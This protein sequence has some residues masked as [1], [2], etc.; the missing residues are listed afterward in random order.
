MPNGAIFLEKDKITYNFYNEKDKTHSHA[1]HAEKKIIN[2]HIV[3][4]HAYSINFKNCSANSS[5]ST[6]KEGK[7]YSNY[8]IGKNPKNWASKVKNYQIVNYNNI[9]SAIDAKFK[10]NSSGLKYDFIVYPNGNH[11]DITLEFDGVNNLKIKNNNLIIKTSVNKIIELRPYA[12]QLI[13]GEKTEVKCEYVLLDN[14]VKFDLPN[15]Y[16][17][18]KILVIDPTLIFSTYSGST[19]D[20]WGMTATFDSNGN[21]FSGGI[22]F[23]VGFPVTTGA[24]QVNYAGGDSV[25]TSYPNGCDIGIIK[26]SPDGT[27]RLWA[28]YLGGTTSEELPHSIIV[29]EFDELLI[30]G[31]T[32]SSDFPVTPTAYDTSF[33][34]G[35]NVTY[36]NV[37]KFTNGTDIYISRLSLDGSQLISSTYIGGSANDGFNFRP[38]YQGASLMHGNDS[39]YYN[40]ADGARGE[41][42]ADSENNIYIGT[43]TFSTDFPTTSSAFQQTSGGLQDGVVCKFDASLSNLI[44]S[45]YIGGSLDDAIYSIDVNNS[46][47]VYVAGGTNSADFVTTPNAFKQNYQGGSADGFVAHISKYGNQIISSTFFGSPNYDQAYFVRLDKQDIVHI[48]GQTK[49]TDSTL[50]YNALYNTPNSG[51]FI[52]KFKNDLDTIEWSTVFGTGNGKPNISI[53]AFAVDICN[54][55]YLS[56]WGREWPYSPNNWTSIEGT[57][58]MDITPNA[59]QSTTDGQ[60]FYIMVMSNDASYLDYGSF[61]GEYQGTDHV[62][63]GTSRFDKRGNIYQS[64]CASC[65]GTQQF[66]TYPNPGVWSNSNNAAN[67]NNAVFRFSFADDFSLAEF[68]IPP[69]GCAPH[70][71]MFNNTSFGA[72][73]IWDFGDGSALSND[74][75]PTHTYTT[76]GIYQ[77]T[78]IANDSAT[79]N[80][81]DTIIK[82]IQIL[83][84]T[85]YSM[86]ELTVCVNQ[87]TQIGIP[88]NSN[89]N[90]TYQ[91][92]PS[93][94]LSDSTISNPFATPQN[95][96]TYILIVSNGTCTDTIVQII[97]VITN[98]LNVIAYSDTSVC[99]NQQINIYAQTNENSTYIWSSNNLFTDTLNTSIND[100]S[101]NIIPN[102]TG[103]YYVIAM[104]N[105]CGN[106]AKDSVLVN[107]YNI[108]ANVISD[109]IACLNDTIALYANNTVLGDTLTFD[110]TPITEIIS[111]ANTSTPNISPTNNTWYFVEYENQF[112]CAILDSILVSVDEIS[113][114]NS[115]VTDVLCHNECNGEISV[116]AS[117]LG[118]I[119][120]IWTGGHS[121]TYNFNLCSGNYT[122]VAIDSYGC[123]DS[124]ILTINNPQLLIANIT[125]TTNA[126]CN[127]LNSNSGTATVTAAGGTPNYTYLWSNGDN[128]IIADSL[129]VGNYTV[130]VTDANL[131]DT[132]ISINISDISNMEIEISV[133]DALCFNQ[134]DG[135]ASINIITAGTS[136]YNYYW[137]NNQNTQTVSNL[138][139]G[140]YFITVIDNDNCARLESVYVGQPTPLNTV[141][142]KEN[143]ICNGDSA[144]ISIN[145]TTGGTPNYS[146]LWNSV[147]SSNT[148]FMFAGDGNLI[149]IDS[150]NC[151][152]TLF[153]NLYQPEII[154]IDTGLI[155]SS[156]LE[157]CNGSI[158]I[159]MDGGVNPYHYIWSNSN[160]TTNHLLNL[161]SGEYSVTMSDALG[162]A[163]AYDFNIGVSNY[164]PRLT[165]SSDDIYIFSGE[166]TN[167][168][169]TQ[170]YS[171]Y[172][173][174]PIN[175]LAHETTSDVIATPTETTTYSLSIIDSFGCSTMDTIT[176]FVS[177]LVC[178]EPYIYV[179]N[180]FSPNDDGNN[181]I[182]Y[183]YGDIIDK[184]YF[185]VYDRWGEIV[186][187]TTDPK[188]GWDGI[189]KGK[190]AD[191]AVFVYYLEIICLNHKTFIK[192]GNVTL[193]R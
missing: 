103:Y 13:N 156:C 142:N 53:T 15:G 22:V 129:F 62:D 164:Y 178:G 190:K 37:I 55:M 21:V 67:C 57:K 64:I 166:S 85:T 87:P 96:I 24:Y 47:D 172:L 20:N 192:K 1:H 98:Q 81:A 10:I 134:C 114:A 111:G 39:L 59:F 167:I 68:D 189:Y 16:D 60:D 27:Q 72:Y 116:L 40:Y 84:D 183:V 88:P 44:F 140:N 82:T 135:S 91:W 56:G 42:I 151:R 121:G 54:R 76:S 146:Y 90:F 110:W 30:F 112:G 79:C 38:N 74:T 126:A 144:Q 141:I 132:I 170:N 77:I 130:T 70:T 50:V 46:D 71:V 165:L 92:I 61:F 163:K 66:P 97:N 19:A 127:G 75:N 137:S 109:T 157:S 174:R 78:L 49:A 191:P 28:S 177:D 150:H 83:S 187:A 184:L 193:I 107:I 161:C 133:T 45:S 154:T 14:I 69:T 58:N 12:Y 118:A 3:N 2:E 128:S 122:I 6:E 7:F 8:F 52:T 41:I 105:I 80:L 124:V 29:N 17:K 34:G 162:C 73:Y 149:T 11:N 120:Y 65:G 145:N 25:S 18:T 99:P 173:W 147:D 31:V 115:T 179:P 43:C 158:I 119:S 131:C 23:N 100:S 89:S 160:I 101:L 159:G 95:T 104:E 155:L 185:A 186:F 176:I 32:G 148:I 175:S 171:Y 102:S 125:D 108:N 188:I 26:Y 123:K 117:G 180:A 35:T 139:A 138:C 48:T 4:F 9:Y 36:D 168:H 106:A 51:Q 113:F 5:I 169:A 33:N 152:D 136:P 86:Q 93:T 181:D 182:L 94:G 63:G 153:F 143:I